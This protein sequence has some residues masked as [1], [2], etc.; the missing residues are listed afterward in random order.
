MVAHDPKMVTAMELM[1]PYEK[2][3]SMSVGQTMRTFLYNRETGAF[4]G[5]TASSWGK[6]DV[7]SF[8]IS[9]TRHG[10]N[11]ALTVGRVVR[12]GW[13][14]VIVS[15]LSLNRVYRDSR[16]HNFCPTLPRCGHT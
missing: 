3:P 8:R 10:R 5:R 14:R 13:L 6:R 9:S 2:P 11:C 4:M 16:D 15:I 1:N 12:C 7:A